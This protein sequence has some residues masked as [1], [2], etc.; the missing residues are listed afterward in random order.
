MLTDSLFCKFK[1]ELLQRDLYSL[2][3]KKGLHLIVQH[4]R[5]NVINECIHSCVKYNSMIVFGYEK[6]INMAQRNDLYFKMECVG[7]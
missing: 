1:D 2:E 7:F 4:T 6:K 3:K 5:T